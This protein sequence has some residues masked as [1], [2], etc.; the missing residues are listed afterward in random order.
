MIEYIAAAACIAIGVAWYR[1]N[2]QL[3][4]VEEPESSNFDFAAV[5][6]KAQDQ[7]QLIERYSAVNALQDDL[8]IARQ[9]GVQIPL[10]LSWTSTTGAKH[11]VHAEVK[12]EVLQEFTKAVMN[13]CA[14]SLSK[15]A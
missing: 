7:Q 2:R 1:H 6:Q 13:E 3:D 4:A 5:Q 8:I 12:P 14:A 9:Q 11:V 15:M 10:N